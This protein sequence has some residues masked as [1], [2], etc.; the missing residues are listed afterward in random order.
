M[1]RVPEAD[2]I[3]D[4]TRVVLERIQKQLANAGLTLRDIAK[5]TCYL[6]EESYR[7]EFVE[8]YREIFAPGPYPARCTVVLGLAGDCRVQIEAVAAAPGV[9]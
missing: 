2:T 5:T 7:M 8:A 4:E 1:K 3:A 9:D 6:R